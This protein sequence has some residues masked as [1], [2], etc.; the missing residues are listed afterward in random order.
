MTE[1]IWKPLEGYDFPYEISNLGR[2]RGPSGE[3]NGSSNGVTQRVSL[4]RGGV[5]SSARMARLVATAFVP[6]PNG[7]IYV[8]QKDGNISNCRA[9]NLEWY[10]SKKKPT[11]QSGSKATPKK[12]P[13]CPRDCFYRGKIGEHHC[14]NYIFEEGHS[15]PCPPGPGCTAYKKKFRSRPQR[16]LLVKN[17]A[18]GCK[19]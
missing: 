15:R 6:N 8:L 1:E 7:G 13:V 19:K 14:C 17:H 12:Q 5:Y 2:L 4:R 3:T 16:G 11:G 9:D 18:G 10:G